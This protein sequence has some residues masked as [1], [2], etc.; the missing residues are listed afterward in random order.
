MSS[1]GDAAMQQPPKLFK[2]DEAEEDGYE[3]QLEEIEAIQNELDLLNDQASEEI[4]RVEQKYNSLRKPQFD[5]RAKAIAKVP[6]FWFTGILNHPVLADHINDQD[7]QAL[8]YLK[9]VHVHEFEEIKSGYKI[10]FAFSANPFFD[11]ETLSKEYKLDEDGEPIA[12]STSIR[13]KPG[14]NLAEVSAVEKGR[15]RPRDA[16][17][18]FFHWFSDV[19][20]EES[21]QIAE[22]IKDD[23]W[24]SPLSFYLG[25]IEQ[26]EDDID[27]EEG[28]QYA[29][30][31]GG[32]E[33]DVHEVVVIGDDEDLEEDLEEDEVEEEEEEEGVDGGQSGRD[34]PPEGEV[35]DVEEED[36]D[37]EADVLGDE[38]YEE[39]GDNDEGLLEGED[40][41]GGRDRGKEGTEG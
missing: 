14:K 36:E 5:Q 11:N 30:E 24:P 13:W 28:D 20:D 10:D 31:S 25:Q 15:K 7:E 40:P 2:R 4:L 6:E 23:L 12:V 32:E 1:K 17:R 39:D 35:Y 21:D 18:G 19:Q 29:A 9:N 26:V 41:D 16:R 8:R 33:E 22:A 27:E 37:E 34:P 38:E 3:E